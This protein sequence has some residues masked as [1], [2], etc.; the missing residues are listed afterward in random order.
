M[1]DQG[2]RSRGLG[3]PPPALDQT[4]AR[5]AEKFGEGD[6]TPPPPPPPPHP[7]PG[8]G[9]GGGGGGAPPPP[10]PQGYFLPE[11][12]GGLLH[13]EFN[14]SWEALLVPEVFSRVRRGASATG[15]PVLGRRPK[16]RVAEP[17]QKDLTETGNH[18]A[19]GT[20]GS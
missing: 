7:S 19:S 12:I 1:A 2:E 14:M 15:R 9:G 16:R 3:T 6:R 20:Q 8:G 11:I 17:R 10:P 5:R 4:D 18:A 13:V